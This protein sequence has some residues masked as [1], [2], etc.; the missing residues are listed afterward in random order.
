MTWKVS[1][2]V[3]Q[4]IEFVARAISKKEP[5]SELCREYGIS[6]Q[7]GHLWLKRYRELGTFA[8]LEDRSHAAVHVWNRSQRR[9][10]ELVLQIR[11]QDGWA[12]RKIQKILESEHGIRIAARTVDRILKRE[13]CIQNEELNRPALK[14]FEREAPNELWQMDFKGQY[15]TQS[16][17]C[18][19]LSILDDHSRYVVGLYALD[20]TSMEGV[21]DGLIQTFQTYGL[22]DQ[23][24]TDHGTPW[25]NV[26]SPEAGLTQI[27]VMLLK[28]NVKLCYS[29]IGHP[30]TQGKVERFHK[31]MA[32]SLRYRGEPQ[33]FKEWQASLDRIRDS[34]N[35]RRP[36]E[37]LNM[38]VPAQ[39]YRPS[40]RLFQLH[41][42]D[43]SYSDQWTVA[44]LNG[45]GNLVYGR[46]Q[47]FVSK[48]LHNETVAFRAVESKL[49]V[50]FRHTYVREIDLSRNESYAFVSDVAEA[51]VQTAAGEENNKYCFPHQL[52][53]TDSQFAQ[54]RIEDS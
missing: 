38:A 26:N 7:T 28:Q 49:L 41:P 11:R 33:R 5:V 48:A 31:T 51:P 47:Y 36:H 15:R 52:E 18:Y 32:R 50:R 22:P 12:G 44:R 39:R 35:N 9:I 29:G 2:V 14:R 4:R 30:Q 6:R 20:S 10:E 37:S 13:G 17:F 42:A 19:P 27:G 43:W 45:S 21:R 54:A 53:S 46:R 24:L 23:L 40:R 25:W 3:S 16:G 1:N 8:A 34:Y